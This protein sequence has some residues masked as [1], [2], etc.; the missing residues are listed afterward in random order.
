MFALVAVLGL[1]GFV[2]FEWLMWRTPEGPQPSSTRDDSGAAVPHPAWSSSRPDEEAPAAQA[3]LAGRVLELSGAPIAEAMVCAVYESGT[4]ETRAHA[5][6]CAVTLADGKYE[7][8]H[9]EAARA[10][11]LGAT[12]KGHAPQTWMGK[13]GEKT[14]RLADGERKDNVD[15]VL[16]AGGVA[17]RGRVKDAL[18]GVVPGAL[19]TISPEEPGA[20]IPTTTDPKGEFVAWVTPGLVR[21]HASAAGYTDAYGSGHAPQHRFELSL[22]PASAIVGR[23][24]DRATLVPV[25]NARIDAIAVDQMGKKSAQTQEDGTFRIEGLAPGKY[26]LEGMAPGLSGYARAPLVVGV[27]DTSQEVVVELERSPAVNARVLESDTRAPC[28]GGEVTLHDKRVGEY[29]IGTIE[30]DGAVHFMAVLPGTYAVEV[31]CDDHA[32]KSKYPAVTVGKT[33]LAQIVWEVDRGS[34][35]R[36]FVV[37]A[38]GKPVQNASVRAEPEDGQ[39]RPSSQT[40]VKGAFALL[41]LSSGKYTITASRESAGAEV[42]E[43]VEVDGHRP[44]TDVRL[45]LGKGGK[46]TGTVTD[47]DGKPAV[48]VTVALTGPTYARVET[49]DDGTYAATGLLGGNYRVTVSSSASRLR[50]LGAAGEDIG[51]ALQLKVPAGGDVKKPLVVERRGG[52]IEGNVVDARG[53]ALPDFFVDFLRSDKTVRGSRMGALGEGRVIT[54]ARGHFR[55]ENL[56]VGEY[57]VRAFRQ[58]GAQ[59]ATQHVKTGAVD[60]RIEISPQGAVTGVVK[61][62][63]GQVP[64]RFT[65]QL[66]G[67]GVHRSEPFFHT[68]G[69]FAMTEL[70]PGSYQV[71]IDAPEGTGTG[72]AVITALGNTTLE[73]VLTPKAEPKDDD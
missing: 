27:A 65:V 52:T 4:H 42:Q 32:A 1:V 53:E 6:S 67:K 58:S 36:G 34:E 11:K 62:D 51:E 64:D 10:F 14:L 72:T 12:A 33:E 29:A 60:A 57:T 8:A 26:R 21:V 45:E 20:P 55:L 18:G 47:A 3:Q 31:A 50:L 44:A 35:V 25:P 16:A 70:G 48:G 30:A 17:V 37:D 23:A 24:I 38:A 66:S 54:D 40:D 9:L 39:S 22:L 69:A 73:I 71:E 28:H 19:V 43:H 2:A 7:L 49:H 59:G 61:T 15:L 63:R 68:Q 13:A 41:G 5:P 56:A 46:L